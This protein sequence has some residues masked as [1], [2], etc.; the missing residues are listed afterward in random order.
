[1]SA[2]LLFIFFV[3]IYNSLS[4]IPFPYFKNISF[5]ILSVLILLLLIFISIIYCGLSLFNRSLMSSFL[6]WKL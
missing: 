5:I 2:L 1:M 6:F 3:S 4:P